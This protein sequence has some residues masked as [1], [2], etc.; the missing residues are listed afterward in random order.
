[1]DSR[2][3]P[4]PRLRRTGRGND[5][6]WGLFGMTMRK[7]I[8]AIDGPSAS[9]KG[10]VAR[11]LAEHFGYAYLDTGLLYRAFGLLAHEAGVN[12]D[13]AAAM[14]LFAAALPVSSIT[15]RLNDPALKGDVAAVASS[16]SGA[17]PA[18]RAK[19]L[20]LQ[21][22]FART[23]PGGKKGAVLDGR[24]IGTVICPDAPV[25]IYVTANTETRA[26][27][28]WKELQGRGETATYANVLADLQARDERDTKRA[29]AP[30]LP[31]SDA[32]MLDSSNMTADEVFAEALKIAKAKL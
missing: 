4:T 30:A 28:R 6:M 31:A 1:M 3:P 27:R 16:K 10:T 8:I 32:V 13:D 25:K 26:Q 11:R 2:F 18:V 7:N 9:G 23:P 17:V 15:N 12:L 19:L 21:Q 14:T 20:H 22:D 29:V 5:A 24:D